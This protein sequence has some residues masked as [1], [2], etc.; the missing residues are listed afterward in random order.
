[1]LL[2]KASIYRKIPRIAKQNW[3][4]IKNKQGKQFQ[5]R[6]EKTSIHEEILEAKKKTDARSKKKEKAEDWECFQTIM[7]MVAKRI[8][9]RS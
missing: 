1:M 2:L 3:S 5:G 7:C 8:K 6:E 9:H 4:E